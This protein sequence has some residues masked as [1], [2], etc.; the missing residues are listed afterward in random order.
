MAFRA[1]DVPERKNFS[2]F[3]ELGTISKKQTVTL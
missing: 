1:A 2:S 3:E